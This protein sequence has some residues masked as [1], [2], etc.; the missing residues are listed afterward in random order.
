MY[1]LRRS[2]CHRSFQP[3]S[4]ARRSSGVPTSRHSMLDLM[5]GEPVTSQ[6]QTFYRTGQ[7]VLASGRDGY[8]IERRVQRGPE[9]IKARTVPVRGR[10][11]RGWLLDDVPTTRPSSAYTAAPRDGSCAHRTPIAAS[12]SGVSRASI[13]AYSAPS[14]RM[15]PNVSRNGSSA[16][17]VRA[18]AAALAVPLGSF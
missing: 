17:K 1:F 4:R 11:T 6:Q 3:R 12:V 18:R 5:E 15:S 9:H 13:A 14:T 2:L 7:F 16:V 10:C 8:R